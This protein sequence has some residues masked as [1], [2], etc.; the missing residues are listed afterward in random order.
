MEDTIYP[1]SSWKGQEAPSQHVVKDC[2]QRN[3]I[4]SHTTYNCWFVH[5]LSILDRSLIYTLP[6][7]NSSPLN[8][9]HPKRR[10]DF[11]PS[12]FRCYGS[13]REGMLQI[14]TISA[15]TFVQKI[16]CKRTAI[17]KPPKRN[18]RV[19]SGIHLMIG[20]PWLAMITHI[21]IH[22]KYYQYYTG[23]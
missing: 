3:G 17:R 18:L 2:S 19:T 21:C 15:Q 10:V 13:F 5:V 9:G 16:Y 20:I 14:W 1:P 12:I 23:L 8:I 11:Q 4:Q 7:T 6:E 22:I